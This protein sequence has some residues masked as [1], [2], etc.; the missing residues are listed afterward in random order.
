LKPTAAGLGSFSM[1][2]FGT[3]PNQEAGYKDTGQ[4]HPLCDIK[5]L[6]YTAT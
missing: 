2:P 3:S 6:I 4:K 1:K 5:S